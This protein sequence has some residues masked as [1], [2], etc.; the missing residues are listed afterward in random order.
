[1][2]KYYIF[3]F[4]GTL[5]NTFYD[6]VIAYNKAL[7]QHNL[8]EYEYE[9]LS[10]IDYTDFTTNMTEDMDVLVTYGENLEND[11][12]KY[13]KPYPGVKKVLKQLTSEGNEVAICSNRSEKQLNESVEKFFNEI[14]FTHVIGYT[15]DGGFKPQPVVINRILN[16]V[17]YNKEEIL[18]IG[19]KQE[20]IQT[21]KNVD[22]D[23]VIVTWGQGNKETYNDE[24]PI[25][26]I[27]NINQLLEI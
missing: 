9:S 20:D 1:M 21:A 14:P 7:R 26:I 8:P 23:A 27:D 24:Y 12:K 10:D 17:S 15:P 18:Y 5:V 13:T 3:D 22:I 16:D 6:S 19:D 2:K 11:E 4:D 25:K